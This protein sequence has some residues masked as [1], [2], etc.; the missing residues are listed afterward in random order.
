MVKAHAQSFIVFFFFYMSGLRGPLQCNPLG[1]EAWGD[2]GIFWWEFYGS[3]QFPDPISDQ[4]N[5]ILIPGMDYRKR[6]V[7]Y[8]PYP[9][10]MQNQNP[11]SDSQTKTAKKRH[12]LGPHIP[13]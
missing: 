6:S 1:P 10:Q 11:F 4:K 8:N 13:I 5:V 3:I 2:G 7:C 9:F 12:P